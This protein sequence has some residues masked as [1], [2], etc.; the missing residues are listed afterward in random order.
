MLKNFPLVAIVAAIAISLL[1]ENLC[2]AEQSD[3]SAKVQ[4]AFDALERRPLTNVRNVELWIVFPDGLNLDRE[5]IYNSAKVKL[6]Q[7]GINA[8]TYSERVR[9]STKDVDIPGLQIQI[10]TVSRGNFAAY[11]GNVELIESVRTC[12]P[13]SIKLTATTWKKTTAGTVG[14]EKASATVKEKIDNLL[15]T[16]L[17]KWHEAN[18]A[19]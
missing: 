2:R 11:F 7:S 8:Q 14:I 15:D 5:A 10:I 9:N 19:Q 12:R 3:V 4:A 13:Q 16:F 17:V 1:A 6:L 18:P